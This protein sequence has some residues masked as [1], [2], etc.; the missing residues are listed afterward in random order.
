MPL[1]FVLHFD[2]KFWGFAIEWESGLNY[3]TGGFGTRAK[4]IRFGMVE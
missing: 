2:G 3:R 1:S 4:A